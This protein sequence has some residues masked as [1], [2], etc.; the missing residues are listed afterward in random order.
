MKVFSEAFGVEELPYW[1]RASRILVSMGVVLGSMWVNVNRRGAYYY[2]MLGLRF[3]F[4][5]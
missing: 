3:N 4:A 1:S 2:H 5:K